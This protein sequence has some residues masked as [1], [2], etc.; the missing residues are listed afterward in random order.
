M[1]YRGIA[2]L[3]A[4]C[5]GIVLV[6]YSMQTSFYPILNDFWGNY[7]L[8]RTLRFEDSS[9][10]YNAFFPVGYSVILKIMDSGRNPAVN[11][12]YLNIGFL[13]ILFVAMGQ[14]SDSL[15]LRK[16]T[17]IVSLVLMAVFPKLFLYF[18]TVG[19]DVGAL[20]FFSAG[21]PASG[22]EKNWN[23]HSWWGFVGSGRALEIPR[24]RSLPAIVAMPLSVL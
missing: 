14:L 3:F 2:F 12:M 17:L 4:V 23:I 1:T 13:T 9:T 10:L 19:A 21:W 22:Q 18:M 16:S 8:S 11:A 5:L 6:V 24:I 15:K 20:T 7:Y